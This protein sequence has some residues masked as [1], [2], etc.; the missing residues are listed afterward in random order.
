MLQLIQTSA[1]DTALQAREFSKK[2]RELAVQSSG[3]SRKVQDRSMIDL[4][5]EVGSLK[6]I[7]AG[8]TCIITQEMKFYTSA[9]DGPYNIGRTIFV[10]LTSRYESALESGDLNSKSVS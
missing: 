10:F 9:L 4:D 7:F 2:R 1:H 6:Y 3:A 5:H 8:L